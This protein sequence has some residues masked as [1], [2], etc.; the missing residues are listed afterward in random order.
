MHQE[1]GTEESTTLNGFIKRMNVCFE[2][3]FET[4]IEK[5]IEM[6]NK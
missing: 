1:K 5:R 2:S 6:T 4:R 3:Q